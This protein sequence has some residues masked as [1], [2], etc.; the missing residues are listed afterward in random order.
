MKSSG[1]LLSIL[2]TIPDP[3]RAEG[4]LYQLPHVLLFSIFAIVTGASSYRGIQTYFTAYR[5]A[6]NKVF[7]I[8][9]KRAP[10]HTA[11]RHILQ[12]L[13]ATNLEKA[14]REH[15]ANLSVAPGGAETCVFAFDGKTLKGSFDNFNDAKA[16][17]VLSAF[18]VDTALVL[19]HIEIDEKSNEIPAVQK[20][21]A[22]LDV[23]GRI[24]TCDAKHAQK[25]L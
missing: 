6:L 7:K 16:K 12:G 25:N 5:Q 1:P 17:Q 11:I 24:F 22:E 14:F 19:A 13:D 3:R 10:A 8:K 15:S 20:L 18:A 23:A 2:A 4:K 21:L 9:W